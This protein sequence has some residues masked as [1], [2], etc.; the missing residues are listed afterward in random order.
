MSEQI[1]GRPVAR[2]SR[3]TSGAFSGQTEGMTI[4]SASAIS[5]PT[6]AGA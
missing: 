1:T 3:A 4:Q 6:S 5:R 2:A